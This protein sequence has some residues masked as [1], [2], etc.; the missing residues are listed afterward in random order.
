MKNFALA[1]TLATTTSALHL[2]TK[3]DSDVALED[4]VECIEYKVLDVFEGFT[5]DACD[6]DDYSDA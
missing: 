4:I 3:G 1:L 5:Y 6:N 2:H